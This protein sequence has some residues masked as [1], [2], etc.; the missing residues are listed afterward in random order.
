MVM[1][2]AAMQ[3]ARRVAGAAA[4]RRLMAAMT[5]AFALGQLIGPLTVSAATAAAGDPLAPPSL[6]AAALLVAGAGALLRRRR[7]PDLSRHTPEGRTP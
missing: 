7:A 2:M 5:A 1:T 3:E 4:P 6:V